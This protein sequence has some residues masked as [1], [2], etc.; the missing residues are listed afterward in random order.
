MVVDY[1]IAHHRT[2]MRIVWTIEHTDDV[3]SSIVQNRCW[4]T[5]AVLL[6]FNAQHAHKN[7]KQVKMKSTASKFCLSIALSFALSFPFS[8]TA[9]EKDVSSLA[10]T[11][12]YPTD[13]KDWVELRILKTP[14]RRYTD[15]K[16][17]GLGVRRAPVGQSLDEF[18]LSVS[19]D[20]RA[21]TLATGFEASLQICQ[22]IED[23]HLNGWVTTTAGNMS[24]VSPSSCPKNSGLTGYVIHT[25]PKAVLSFLNTA[26][27]SAMPLWA[28]IINPFVLTLPELVSVGDYKNGKGYLITPTRVVFF[29]DKPRIKRVLAGGEAIAR[30]NNDSLPATPPQSSQPVDVGN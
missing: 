1:A 17:Y 3:A 4:T 29:Q 13:S 25:H 26:D 30:V 28:A 6:P 7:K 8:A 27:R 21:W 14:Y 2:R 24:S 11:G 20:M 5:D 22:D 18:V 15:V 9:Q 19:D 16:V 10:S 23:S 12:S